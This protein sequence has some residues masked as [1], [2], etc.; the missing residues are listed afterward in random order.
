M[1]AAPTEEQLVA[2]AGSSGAALLTHGW[3]GGVAYAYGH[4]PAARAVAIGFRGGM[5]RV[6]V[7]AEGWWQFLAVAA[8]S[9]PVDL[10]RIPSPFAVPR[11]TGRGGTPRIAG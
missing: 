8:E 3:S 9:D 11:G 7:N 1:P 5:R 6:P 4:A 2:A 10:S